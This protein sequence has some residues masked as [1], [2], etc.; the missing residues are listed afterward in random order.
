[1][2]NSA[3]IIS[4]TFAAAGAGAALFLK[5]GQS[6]RYTAVGNTDFAGVAD[7][8]R[9]EDGGKSWQSIL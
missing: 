9:S 3:N 7:L 8:E 2:S 5:Q 1:M 6:L 4:K